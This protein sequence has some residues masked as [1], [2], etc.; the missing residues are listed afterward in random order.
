MDAVI[1]Y[2]K[3]KR[4]G[5]ALARKLDHLMV[6]SLVSMA[7]DIAA[8]FIHAEHHHFGL[9]VGKGKLGEALP[10]KFPNHLQVLGMAGNLQTSLH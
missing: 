2:R 3:A 8:G 4:G 6:V 1:P 9:G 10:Y 7:D 5:G